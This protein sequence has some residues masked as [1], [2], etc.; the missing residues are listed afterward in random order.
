MSEC[1]GACALACMC[2]GLNRCVCVCA[3]TPTLI[4]G[5]FQW[6]PPLGALGRS[7]VGRAL[8]QVCINV[9]CV[10][11]GMKVAHC[12]SQSPGSLSNPLRVSAVLIAPVTG[13]LRLL[14]TL[15]KALISPCPLDVFNNIKRG[16]YIPNVFSFFEI[17]RLGF[18]LS[19]RILFECNLWSVAKS[20]IWWICFCVQG[21]TMYFS[22]RRSTWP[23][24]FWYWLIYHP[25]FFMRRFIMYTTKCHE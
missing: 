15:Q 2:V 14:F 1:V 7:H 12:Y 5:S 9:L 20:A 21:I 17:K 24:L 18:P 22:A 25:Y 3:C 4:H 23:T 11:S 19:T 10:F 16:P 8:G 13:E 6:P